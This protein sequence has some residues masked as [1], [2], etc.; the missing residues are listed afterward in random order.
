MIIKYIGFFRQKAI[1]YLIAIRQYSSKKFII[2][3]LAQFSK[4][5]NINRTDAILLSTL[6]ESINAPLVST[7]KAKPSIGSIPSLK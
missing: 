5:L 2:G 6:N 1:K 4:G 3:S 7:A